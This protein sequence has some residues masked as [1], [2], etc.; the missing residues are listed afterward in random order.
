MSVGGASIGGLFASG[1]DVEVSASFHVTA[2]VTATVRVR[3]ENLTAGLEL[4]LATG[5]DLELAVPTDKELETVMATG[6]DLELVYGKD[7]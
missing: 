2:T 5:I 1:Q 4:I 6:F 7:L 3:A